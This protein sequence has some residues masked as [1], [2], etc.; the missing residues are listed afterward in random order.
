MARNGDY[1]APFPEDQNRPADGWYKSYIR[2]RFH[3]N[4]FDY[5]GEHTGIEAKSFQ[6]ELNDGKQRRKITWRAIKEQRRRNYQKQ[7]Q[8]KKSDGD[9]LARRLFGPK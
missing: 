9:K 1:N 6:E 5:P 8:R 3:A 2:E 4:G 7:H